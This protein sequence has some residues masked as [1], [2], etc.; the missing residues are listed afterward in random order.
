MR[1]KCTVI[2]KGQAQAGL[3]HRRSFMMLKAN[4]LLFFFSFVSI[5]YVPGTVFKHNLNEVGSQIIPILQMG[6]LRQREIG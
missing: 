4:A 2:V 5:Y 6:K 1:I 3:A